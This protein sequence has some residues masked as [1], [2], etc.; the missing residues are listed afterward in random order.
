MSI[1]ILLALPIVFGIIGIAIFSAEHPKNH[2]NN[3]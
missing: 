3:D 2:N 1:G